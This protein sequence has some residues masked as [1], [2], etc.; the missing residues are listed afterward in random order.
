MRAN[1]NNNAT[2]DEKR[3]KKVKATKVE[4]V[5]ELDKKDA[6]KHQAKKLAKEKRKAKKM[7][8]KAQLLLERRHAKEKDSVIT[9]TKEMKKLMRT[10]SVI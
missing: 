1:M 9:E 7:A 3:E 4:I 10:T 8:L 6:A 5:I 2:R